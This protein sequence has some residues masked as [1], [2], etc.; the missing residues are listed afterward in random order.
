MGGAFRVD[1]SAD[2]SIDASLDAELRAMLA[3]SPWPDSEG[4]LPGLVF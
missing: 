2:A 3:S 1:Y 4:Y